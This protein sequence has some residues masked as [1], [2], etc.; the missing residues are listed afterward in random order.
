MRTKVWILIFLFITSTTVALHLTF[1]PGTGAPLVGD[2]QVG[3]V[4]LDLF[5]STN[6]TIMGDV[7]DVT[8]DLNVNNK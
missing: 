6:S 7:G 5:T 1:Y 4:Q 2:V 8:G 3:D